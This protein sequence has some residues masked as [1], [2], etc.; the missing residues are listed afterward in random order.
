M[1]AGG[2][3]AGASNEHGVELVSAYLRASPPPRGLF[4]LPSLSYTVGA[5]WYYP[6][7]PSVTSSIGSASTNELCY[8]R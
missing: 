7:A 8:T 6:G 4:S 5:F 3:A 2:S 1:L